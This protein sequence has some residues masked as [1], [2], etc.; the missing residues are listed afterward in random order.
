LAGPN[1]DIGA[2]VNSEI[3]ATGLK[4][5]YNLSDKTSLELDGGATFVHYQSQ[6]G[7]K[8]FVNHDW[9]NYNLTP[10]VTVSVGGA[11][12]VLQ[13]DSGGSQPY[14]Q[15]LF[16]VQFASTAKLTFNGN[17]GVEFREFSGSGGGTRITPV[18]GLSANYA[19][20]PGT[21]FNL[22]GARNVTNS[23]S[24]SGDNYTATRISGDISQHLIGDFY[25]GLEGGYENDAYSQATATSTGKGQ[26]ED[27]YFFV[28][29]SV[30]YHLKDWANIS[31]SYFYRDNNSNIPNKAF[32]NN[33]VWVEVRF[34]F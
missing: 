28:R 34:G 5:S 15:A 10:K 7:S 33:Q 14:Q 12:G 11:F 13:P 20:S 30:T 18:F 23:S 32:R 8:E 16:R 19:L 2:R 22:N 26:R 3:Y 27:N 21:Q 31:V 17:A 25:M 6:I 9:L 29:P 1:R 4:A 24:I